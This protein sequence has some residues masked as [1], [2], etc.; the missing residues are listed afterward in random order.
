M[1]AYDSVSS[2]SKALDRRPQ[3]CLL[4]DLH[5]PGI[6]GLD[7][8]RD[9][10]SITDAMANADCPR[11]AAVERSPAQRGGES[12]RSEPSERTD[13]SLQV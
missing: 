13:R 12:L 7:A 10:S 9:F 6:G 4:L 1:E 5:M 3:D 11:S 8:L 2:F